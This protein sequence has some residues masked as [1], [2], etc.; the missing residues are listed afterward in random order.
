MIRIERPPASPEFLDLNGERRTRE[1]NECRDRYRDDYRKGI[2]KFKFNRGVYS[3]RSVKNALLEAQRWKCCYCETKFR[4][5]SYGAVEH[6][7][8]KGAVRQHSNGELEYP[9]YYWLAYDWTNL[10][11]ACN[12][13]NT[14]HKRNLFPLVDDTARARSHHDDV[15]VERPLFV[16]PARDDPR[17]HIRFR[18]AAVVSVTPRGRATID[19]IGLRRSDLEEERRVWLACVEYLRLIVELEGIVAIDK[20]EDARKQLEEAVLPGARYSAMAQ[21]FLDPDG[22][23]GEG[24]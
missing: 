13:C 3:H 17:Q 22:H 16:D 6:F 20:V 2:R 10:L 24:P 21:D 18:G 12:R 9:G 4:A 19:G 1:N 7:R 23:E 5:S 8:P 11:V 15:H 14:T